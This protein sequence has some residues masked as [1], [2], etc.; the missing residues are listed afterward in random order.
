MKKFFVVGA[1][2]AAGLFVATDLVADSEV[3]AMP[4][5]TNCCS[6]TCWYDSSGNL[7]GCDP[8]ACNYCDLEGK[9]P[10]DIDGG[11]LSFYEAN[12]TNAN[13][14]KS[15]FSGATFKNGHLENARFVWANFRS[16]IF[17]QAWRSNLK[18]ADF[19]N[20][21]L[22]NADM[23][24]AA[25]DSATKLK[26]ANSLVGLRLSSD[27]DG[28][29]CRLTN[30]PYAYC[31][32]DFSDA[33]IRQKCQTASAGATSM[34]EAAQIAGCMAKPFSEQMNLETCGKCAKSVADEGVIRPDGWCYGFTVSVVN[35]YST[36]GKPISDLTFNYAQRNKMAALCPVKGIQ[37][38]GK[39]YEALTAAERA[40]L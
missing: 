21:D 18:G 6:E 32:C 15:N 24:G 33:A 7:T 26:S 5:F 20:A 30:L 35:Y 40:T 28:D 34:A 38:P 3:N 16:A 8:T 4:P 10:G 2:F 37:N 1:L 23:R 17:P 14:A 19:T 39:C 9:E 13:F 22:T 31:T 25:V 29:A 36:S 27:N 12:F 11:G